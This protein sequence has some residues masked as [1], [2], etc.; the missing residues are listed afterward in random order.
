MLFQNIIID[1]FYKLIFQIFKNSI[2]RVLY[3][4]ITILPRKRRLLQKNDM[5]I[6]WTMVEAKPGKEV[7]VFRGKIQDQAIEI[8]DKN[9]TLLSYENN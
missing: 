6:D 8:I 3:L 2:A 5:A 9:S 7:L 4:N 1:N